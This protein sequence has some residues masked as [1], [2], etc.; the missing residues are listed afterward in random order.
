VP[1][2]DVVTQASE[3]EKPPKVQEQRRTGKESRKLVCHTT[4]EFRKIA[5]MVEY[6]T[7]TLASE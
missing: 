2:K 7:R 3:N 1:N 5:S 4:E 6:G